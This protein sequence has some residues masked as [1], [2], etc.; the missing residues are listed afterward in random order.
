V[1]FNLYH[2]GSTIIGR[3]GTEL[4]VAARADV[5][6]D[7]TASTIP[8]AFRELIRILARTTHLLRAGEGTV[9]V[10]IAFIA[11]RGIGHGKGD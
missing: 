2:V 1:E 4:A 6:F 11:V 10:G 3:I 8:C 5:D 9:V 7:P